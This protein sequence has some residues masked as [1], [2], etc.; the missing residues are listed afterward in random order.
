[1]SHD[2]ADDCESPKCSTGDTD[3][4]TGTGQWAC[5]I[6]AADDDLDEAGEHNHNQDA[7]PERRSGEVDHV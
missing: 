1:M 3:D 6:E 4:A 5:A 7:V 2:A